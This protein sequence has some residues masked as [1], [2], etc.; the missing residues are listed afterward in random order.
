[1]KQYYMYTRG[2]RTWIL[3]KS[4]SQVSFFLRI[5]VENSSHTT[6]LVLTPLSYVRQF[7][8]AHLEL[9]ESLL[10]HLHFVRWRP[11]DT[12]NNHNDPDYI[13]SVPVEGI[14]DPNL[15]QLGLLGTEDI[16]AVFFVPCFYG[17]T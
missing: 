15:A 7:V 10:S 5:R 4:L 1:M 11:A 16:E 17:L 3:S 12:E 9:P 8:A 13:V 2:N 14:P 6:S